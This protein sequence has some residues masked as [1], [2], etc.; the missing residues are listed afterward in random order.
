MT[1]K[2]ASLLIYNYYLTQW[3]Q[4]FPNFNK[5]S[6][7]NK[8]SKIKEFEGTNYTFKCTFGTM[9]EYLCYL[10]EMWF[11]SHS[12]PLTF[13]VEKG[14]SYLCLHATVYSFV[15]F[16]IHFIKVL[17]FHK[18]YQILIMTAKLNS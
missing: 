11:Q 3:I 13:S 5:Y 9:I 7:K 12:Q 4:T 2:Y 6:F 1:Y 8:G 14:L 16:K 15:S 18:S 17:T 10:Q